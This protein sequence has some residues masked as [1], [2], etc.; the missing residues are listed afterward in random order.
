M[1]ILFV[2]VT[3]PPDGSATASV[4]RELI[5]Y[6]QKK[7]HEINGITIRKHITD[8]E[9][10]MYGAATIYH[11][12]YANSRLNDW[13]SFVYFAFRK[14]FYYVDKL[15]ST[16]PT[17][18]NEFMVRRLFRELKRIR[19]EKYDCII[20]VCAYYDCA[21]AVLRFAAYKKTNIVFYQVDPL[22][23]NARY[24][25]I[26]NKELESFERKLYDLS[27]AVIT[28]PIIYELKKRAGWNL[29]NVYKLELPLISN[30]EVKT[31]KRD[32]DHDIICV[33]AGFLYDDIRDATFTLELFSNIE[34]PNLKLFIIGMGQEKKLKQYAEGPLK[35]RLIQL[36][37]LPEADCKEWLSKADV[38]VNIGNSVTNQVPS[39]LF[40]YINYGKPILN[41]SK[42]RVCPTVGYL[43]KY[44]LSIT[45]YEDTQDIYATAKAVAKKIHDYVNESIEHSE[46]VHSYKECTANYVGEQ[47]LNIIEQTR[48][49]KKLSQKSLFHQNARRKW[50]F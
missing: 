3:L 35:G 22:L 42:S 23:E 33:Y 32:S 7:G 39:K 20:P 17:V 49:N 36:G 18:Y 24:K 11:A 21:E 13:K 48:N 10:T 31:E 1:K 12:G 16:E 28:T 29:K 26:D 44:P 27:S 4:I 41:I 8:P 34:E 6:F 40:T 37:Q 46:I 45:A 14:V 5:D 9:M 38:L 50:N 2:S 15:L 19:A 47:F 25:T 43:K 30:D